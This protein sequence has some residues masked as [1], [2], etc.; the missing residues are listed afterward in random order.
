MF[1][2]SVAQEESVQRIIK[3]GSLA[4]L[5]VAVTLA[6]CGKDPIRPDPDEGPPPPPPYIPADSTTIIPPE[7]QNVV[8]SYDP[9][10]GAMEIDETSDY[11]KDVVVGTILIGQDDEVAPYGFLLKVTKVT[12]ENSKLILETEPAF[13]SEA[14]EELSIKEPIP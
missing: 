7:E 6:G 2:H 4:M 8:L 1:L 10:T 9:D 5:M 3:L 13:L 14:F 11:A 12:P